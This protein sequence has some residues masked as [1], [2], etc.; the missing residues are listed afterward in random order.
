MKVIVVRGSLFNGINKKGFYKK[1]NVKVKNVPEGTT[2]LD[3]TD[4][5]VGQKPDCIMVYGGTNNITKGI[6]TL[7]TVKKIESK[8]K[9]LYLIQDWP[10][11][12]KYCKKTKSTS[13]K[14]YQ[15]LMVGRI[16]TPRQNS[17]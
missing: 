13:Q 11:P 6:R 8:V 2:V 16:I 4:I 9:I 1:H 15:M 17:I 3:E 7:N 12:A 14:R 5:L 10:F